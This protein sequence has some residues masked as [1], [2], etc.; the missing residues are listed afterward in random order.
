MST[1]SRTNGTSRSI[2]LSAV[3]RRSFTAA[4][5]PALTLRRYKT[6]DS[7][8]ITFCLSSPTWPYPRWINRFRLWPCDADYVQ[9]DGSILVPGLLARTGID[10]VQFQFDMTANVVQFA[11]DPTLAETRSALLTSGGC[12]TATV[13]NLKTFGDA[14]RANH[15]SLV[16]LCHTLDSGTREQ[17]V[18]VVRQGQVLPKI[19][20]LT[21]FGSSP[22]P[23]GCFE[24]DSLHPSSLL[25]SVQSL[26]ADS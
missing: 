10:L 19:L 21:A 5:S 26:I 4:G 9:G 25:R 15:L 22:V 23:T 2:H 14:I 16:I 7:A 20:V 12:S 11:L 18:R 17:A 3:S 24:V 1:G 13:Y 6:F 8:S